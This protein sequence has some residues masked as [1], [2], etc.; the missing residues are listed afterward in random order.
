M[1]YTAPSCH[2]H[3][4]RT[5]LPTLLLAWRRHELHIVWHGPNRYLVQPPAAADGSDADAA[6]A[7]ADGEGEDDD[8]IG[9]VPLDVGSGGGSSS[10]SSGSEDGGQGR[11]ELRPSTASEVHA[12]L[13]RAG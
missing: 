7:D 13:M 2:L 6:A 4:R 12:P 1:D 9:I 10:S 5:L 8:A 3:D 11:A